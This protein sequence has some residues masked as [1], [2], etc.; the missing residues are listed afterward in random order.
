M[1]LYPAY[2]SAVRRAQDHQVQL[3]HAEQLCI[4]QPSISAGPALGISNA[5][6]SYVACT[7]TI[8]GA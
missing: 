5:E 4:G 1:L 6:G 7:A 8:G 3:E 2:L